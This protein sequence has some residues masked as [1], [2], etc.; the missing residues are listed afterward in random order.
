MKANQL[1][2][3]SSVDIMDHNHQYKRKNTNLGYSTHTLFWED[4]VFV[5]VFVFNALNQEETKREANL[6][7]PGA[8]TAGAASL[9]RL[10]F[11]SEFDSLR[12]K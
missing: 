2:K 12:W 8:R 5:F 6:G 9:L 10:N 4:L 7:K 3:C 11:Y 1:V